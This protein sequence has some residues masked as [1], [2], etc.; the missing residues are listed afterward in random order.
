MNP[1]SI[2]IDFQNKLRSLTIVY[3]NLDTKI[4]TTSKL[5]DEKVKDFES[6]FS[7]DLIHSKIEEIR[8]NL[9]EFKSNYSSEDFKSKIDELSKEIEIMRVENELKSKTIPMSPLDPLSM[10]SAFGTINNQE[11]K[12]FDKIQNRLTDNELRSNIIENKISDLDSKIQSRMINDQLSSRNELSKMKNELN[13]KIN[14]LNDKLEKTPRSI[15]D[16]SS[17]E[18]KISDKFHNELKSMRNDINNLEIKLQEKNNEIESLKN[19]LEE[20]N[21]ELSSSKGLEL[22]LTDKFHLD[23]KNLENQLHEKNNEIQT[24]KDKIEDTPRKISDQFNEKINNLEKIN[25]LTL[26]NLELKINNKL[27]EMNHTTAK[28]ADLTEFENKIITSRDVLMKEFTSKLEEIINSNIILKTNYEKLNNQYL[29]LKNNYEKLKNSNNNDSIIKINSKL[30]KLKKSVKSK[31]DSDEIVRNL[32]GDHSLIK[33]QVDSILHKLERSDEK[34]NDFSELIKTVI[35]MQKSEDVNLILQSEIVKN[36]MR[37]FHSGELNGETVLNLKIPDVFFMK[38]KSTYIS[39]SNLAKNKVCFPNNLLVPNQNI[40]S[41]KKY[42]I[43]EIS[44]DKLSKSF[45]FVK[46]PDNAGIKFDVDDSEWIDMITPF[47]N[48]ISKLETEKPSDSYSEIVLNPDNQTNV[49]DLTINS[50]LMDPIHSLTQ[51]N[52]IQ[53]NKFLNEITNI[54]KKKPEFK[55]IDKHFEKSGKI[56]TILYPFRILHYLNYLEFEY[57]GKLD[58]KDLN[59]LINDE[60]VINK[61]SLSHE[62]SSYILKSKSKEGVLFDNIRPK[63]TTPLT[64]CIKNKGNMIDVNWKQISGKIPKIKIVIDDSLDKRIV[65]YSNLLS[66]KYSFNLLESNKQIFGS[67][68]KDINIEFTVIYHNLNLFS[69]LNKDEIT[70]CIT[71]IDSSTPMKYK[72][73]KESMN[74]QK[75]DI[76]VKLTGI[77]N[78]KPEKT[79][80]IFQNIDIEYQL[81]PVLPSFITIIISN[82]NVITE[83]FIKPF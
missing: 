21:Q 80:D 53:I 20:S 27:T 39:A 73:I 41:S 5:F 43:S 34:I 22:K 7:I 46:S 19:K 11:L 40:N 65:D 42:L 8:K 58:I 75:S 17:L 69:D 77:I 16:D 64:I 57:P 54:R 78:I 28:I 10:S 50:L 23:L 3:N 4:N 2:L 68:I 79:S 13:Q 62:K 76:D 32:S 83:G 31:K 82:L 38:D 59:L 47:Y 35:S 37:S 56:T 9:D 25:P 26:D 49:L 70:N 66:G 81:P 63:S 18:L 72:W 6:K 67:K 45:I 1:N 61:Y 55:Y 44:Y 71:G 30:D 24:L 29:D 36:C 15:D 60:D 12:Q 74:I 52:S 51:I 48:P 14:D 33:C